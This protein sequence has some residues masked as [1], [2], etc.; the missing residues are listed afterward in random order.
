VLRRPRRVQRR[1]R[2]CDSHVLERSFSPLN[3]GWDSA[4][5]HPYLSGVVSRCSAPTTSQQMEMENDGRSATLETVRKMMAAR[6][7]R[8][9]QYFA[10]CAIEMKTRF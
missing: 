4:A 9:W 2:E 3:A 8:Q 5:R 6:N 7:L 10:A 1:N